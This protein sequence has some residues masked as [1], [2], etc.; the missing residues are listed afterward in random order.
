MPK[1]NKEKQEKLTQPRITDPIG[2][3]HIDEMK[4]KYPP[5]Q[6]ASGEEYSSTLVYVS[7][8]NS[9]FDSNSRIMNMITE[10]GLEPIGYMFLIKSYMSSALSYGLSLDDKSVQKAMVNISLDTDIPIPTL[11]KYHQILI[12]YGILFIINDKAGHRV[13]TER[14]QLY[15]F[16][17]KEYTRI[18][19]KLYKEKH[20]NKEKAADTETEEIIEDEER[21][22]ENPDTDKADVPIL[23]DEEVLGKPAGRVEE[24]KEITPQA[25]KNCSYDFDCPDTPKNDDFGF[26]S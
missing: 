5:K 23:P 9:F 25:N 24:I 7:I 2:E 15:D 17:L 18:K 1:E 4:R 26:F 3:Y 20:S 11:Q 6:A 8:Q 13:L 22:K 16:E 21:S 14:N 10:E 12:D 19:N